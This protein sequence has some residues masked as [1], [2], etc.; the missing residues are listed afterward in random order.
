MQINLSEKILGRLAGSSKVNPV[1]ISDLLT[2]GKD[3]DVAKE[4]N[5][6][7]LSRRIVRCAITING[8]SN[9]IIYLAGQVVAGKLNLHNLSSVKPAPKEKS[10]YCKSCNQDL[11]QKLFAK[12]AHKCISCTKKL[13]K[14]IAKA[15]K[16]AVSAK[17]AK[18]KLAKKKAEVAATRFCLICKEPHHKSEFLGQSQMC[19]ATKDQHER[20][21]A[22][23]HSARQDRYRLKAKEQGNGLSLGTGRP[24]NRKGVIL[25]AETRAK[26]SIGQMARYQLKK[27]KLEG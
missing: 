10:R 8:Q 7:D 13:E 14:P 3:S 25:S 21:K 19:I 24:S 23:M 27:E 5:N 16:Q 2:L 9:E 15:C 6:L 26:I 18:K 22:A 4:L 20:Y 11:P 12:R 1:V 17:L